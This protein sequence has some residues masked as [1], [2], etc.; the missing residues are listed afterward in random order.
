MASNTPQLIALSGREFR[1]TDIACPHCDWSGTAGELL[2]PGSSQ[3]GEQMRYAC[4]GCQQVIATHGGLSLSEIEAELRAIRAE[5][6][7]ELPATLAKLPEP[8]VPEVDGNTDRYRDT[9]DQAAETPAELEFA[10]VRSRIS[11]PA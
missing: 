10:A 11:D 7:E 2:S 6:A 8:L 5:L 9:D 3:L 1:A 4:P